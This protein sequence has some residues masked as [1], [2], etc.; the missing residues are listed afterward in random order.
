MKL[1][2]IRDVCACMTQL[3]WQTYLNLERELLGLADTIYINDEQQEVYSMRVADLLI[4]TVIEI[5]ALV[6]ELYL[7]NGGAVVPDEEMYFDTVC[8][9]FLDGLWN[10]DKKVVQVVSPSI[11]FEKD[12]NKQFCPLHKASKRGTSSAD[13]NKA[14]QAVKHNRMKELS[15]GSIKNL[16]HGLAALYVLNLYYR[17]LKFTGLSNPDKDNFNRSFGSSLFAVKIHKDKG[18]RVDGVFTKGADFDECVYIEDHEPRSKKTAMDAMASLN[19]Y[20]KT[21]TIAELERQLK[22]MTSRGEQISQEW[23]QTFKAGVNSKIFPINDYRLGKQIT[24]GL[25]QL[26]YDIVLNKQQY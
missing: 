14:Y 9:A 22:E 20:E 1:R 26:R 21:A 11:Y 3:Y 13:W 5:E 6:K 7:N 24:D 25:M 16:I 8:M 10:L 18:L 2:A 4:R 23:L 19:E 12:E 17:D 15:K